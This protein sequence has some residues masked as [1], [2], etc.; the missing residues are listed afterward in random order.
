[1]TAPLGWL[2]RNHSS[3]F[4]P[5][6]PSRLRT[7]I[8]NMSYGRLE[9]VYL[10]FPV[11]FWAFSPDPLVN[12]SSSPSRPPFFTQFISPNYAPD[13]NPSRWTLE[14]LSL[15]TLPAPNAH[16][17]LLFYLNGPCSQ[18]VTS[19]ISSLE[20]TSPK[21]YSILSD[22]FHPYYS[23]LPN[24]NPAS[25]D[26][27]PMKILSTNWQNDELAGCGSYTNF[28]VSSNR[29]ATEP[30]QHHLNTDDGFNDINGSEEKAEEDDGAEIELDR[31]IEALREGCPD[32]GIWFAGEHT[33]PFIALGTVTGAYWSGEAVGRRIAAAYGIGHEIG[34]DEVV[35]ETN[36]EVV[37]PSEGHDVG[38]SSNGTI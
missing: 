12:L 21:Y 7:A 30:R 3:T 25:P 31:D 24:Y 1:M 10:T 28:Q 23:R 37:T 35:A 34:N 2:K 8:R 4:V 15:A 27:Q 29:A 38:K 19:L 26:C 33:A 6:L 13:Q 36:G 17:T 5:S 9:K 18:H 16:P 32:R 14:P 11:P 20:P 22:F